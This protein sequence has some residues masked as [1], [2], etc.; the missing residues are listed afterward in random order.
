M[1]WIRVL[2]LYLDLSA[3][4]RPGTPLLD[5]LSS[6]PLPVSTTL[7]A[8]DKFLLRIWPREKQPTQGGSSLPLQLPA[9]SQI[10]FAGKKKGSLSGSTL[11]F[12]ATG[13]TEIQ[14]G[15]DFYYQTILNTQTTEL[16]SA[17]A[18]LTEESLLSVVDIEVQ[19]SG[20]TERC[21]FQFEVAVKQQAY[22]GEASP[23]PSSPTY[24]NPSDLVTKNRGTVTVANGVDF[25]TVTGLALSFVPAQVLVQ[26]RKPAGGAN[27]FATTRDAS[28]TADGFT[29]D[30]S[31]QTT[32]AGYKLDYLLIAP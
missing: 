22:A 29:V 18:A 3:F 30:L 7:I 16:G 11:L 19:N 4:G 27:L 28:I 12:S 23:S 25:H 32:A 24:P 1:S 9:S 31:G 6:S 17:M 8:N 21:T 5:G 15:V 2:N 14:D 13:F 26:T 20:N 10:V